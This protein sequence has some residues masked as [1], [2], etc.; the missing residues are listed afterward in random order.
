M[1]SDEEKVANT[2]V[3][4][5]QCSPKQLSSPQ[6]TVKETHLYHFG[7]TGIEASKNDDFSFV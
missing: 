5:A 2:D 4:W 6:R 3:A 1:R 7:F